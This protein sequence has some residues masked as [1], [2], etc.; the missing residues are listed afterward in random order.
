MPS[1]MESC[2]ES[3]IVIFHRYAV[4]DGDIKTLSKK[5]LKKL[6]DNELPVFTKAQNNPKLVDYIMKDLDLNKDDKLDFQEFIPL[7]TGLSM[8]CEKIYNMKQKKCKSKDQ[9]KQ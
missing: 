7:F 3:L 9:G 5:E 6:L 2:I 4:Q 8:N 1:E